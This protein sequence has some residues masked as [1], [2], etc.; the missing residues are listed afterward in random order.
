MKHVGSLQ[1]P[2]KPVAE[3]EFCII[4]VMTY[5]NHLIRELC[6]LSRIRSTG[7]IRKKNRFWDSSS[8]C[9]HD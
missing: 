3:M 7:K 8:P 4:L 9:P 1:R 2:W 6:P 5:F